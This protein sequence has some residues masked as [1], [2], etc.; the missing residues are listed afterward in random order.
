[1]SPWF[2]TETA[3]VFNAHF[4]TDKS[5]SE[6]FL[7]VFLR[8]KKVLTCS[9]IWLFNLRLLLAPANCLEIV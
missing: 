1:M 4:R 6:H 8:R 2:I 3:R 5:K 9:P 7:L